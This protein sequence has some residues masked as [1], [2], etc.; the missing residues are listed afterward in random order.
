[1]VVDPF[2]NYP[3]YVLRRASAAAMEKLAKRLAPLRLR[4]SEATVLSLIEANPHITQSEI[5]RVLHIAR[6]NMTPLV[7][8]LAAL[9]LVERRPVDGRSHGLCV[10]GVGRSLTLK[11]RNEMN[12]HEAELL[13]KIPASQRKPFLACLHALWTSD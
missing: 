4:P 12:A 1:L 3:G 9:K 8:R 2:K 13:S 5:G 11:A 7:A 6:A 10:T